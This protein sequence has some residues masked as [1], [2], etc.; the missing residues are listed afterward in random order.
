MKKYLLLLPLLLISF[1]PSFGAFYVV[2]NQPEVERDFSSIQ[3]AIEHASS[4]DTI[5]VKGSPMNY[6][7]VLLEKPLVLIGEGFSADINAGH[8]AK[9]TRVLFTANPY[10]RTISSGSSVIGFEFPYFPGQRANIITVANENVNIEN[11]TIER[12]WLWF[13]EV[14]GSADRWVF[15]NNII[16]GWIKGGHKDDNEQAGASNFLFQNNILNSLMNFH[17]DEMV[18][19]N[20]IILGRLKNIKGALLVNN[21]FTRDEYFLEDVSDSRFN[22]NL[23]VSKKVGKELCYENTE[24]FESQNMCLGGANT[25]SS[26]LTGEDPGFVF[27]PTDDIM[28]GTVFKLT[29][30]SP[31]RSAGQGGNEIG[32]FGGTYPFPSHAFLNPEIDDPFPSFVTSI[33]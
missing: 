3:S 19:E 27:W 29:E 31:G 14:V 10:R 1:L 11:I 7:N 20:N 18:I 25:G 26:N 6:G 8:T 22:N 15:R 32:I 12:N 23:A 28:G 16:R 13:V 9:I 24:Q 17:K 5:F 33:Y 21:I 2:S 4:F 30:S